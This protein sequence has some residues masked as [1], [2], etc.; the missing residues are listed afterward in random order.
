MKILLSFC[1][2]IGAFALLSVLKAFGADYTI[3]DLGAGSASDIND[4]GSVVGVDTS[5]V[6]WYYHKGIKQGLTNIVVE[7]MLNPFGEHE[8]RYATS[9]SGLRINNQEYVAGLAAS[10]T[11]SGNGWVFEDYAPPRGG[12]ITVGGV[13]TG[14]YQVA[15]NDSTPLVYSYL[16]Y[17]NPFDAYS[18]VSLVMVPSVGQYVNLGR[19]YQVVN[20]VNNAG[21]MAGTVGEGASGGAFTDEVFPHPA[22]A[23]IISNLIVNY[24]DPRS[25]GSGFVWEF[26]P[27]NRLS[28]AYGINS[29]GHVVGDMSLVLFSTNKNAFIY[30][31][32]GLENLGTLGGSYST[33]SDINNSDALVG[34]S[35]ATDG[36]LRAFLWTDGIMQDLNALISVDSGW[37]LTKAVAINNFGQIVGEGMHEGAVHAFL[38]SPPGLATAPY[39]TEEPVGALLGVD[40]AYQLSVTAIGT[41]P[42]NYQWLKDGTN[43]PSQ[44]NSVF[45][46]PGVSGADAGTYQAVV[47]NTRGSANSKVVRIDVL[48]PKLAI[49]SQTE[50]SYKLTINGHIGGNY[51]ME[52]AAHP[53][54]AGGWTPVSDF[55]LTNSVQ[56]FV[57]QALG[58][59]TERYYRCVRLP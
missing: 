18:A 44:T 51:R 58:E 32:S 50:T 48:D 5:S 15:L 22:R 30:R 46:F 47:S 7:D 41:S 35:T 9:V 6:G 33:A 13:P 21:L 16:Q 2:S 25:P 1:L 4:A 8:Y 43:L 12:L 14:T 19:D 17:H 55:Q 37:V 36:S 3:T 52:Y 27:T 31:G 54:G 20:A 53:N 24:I 34:Q 23:C 28:D 49:D 38:L 26:N 45:D 59:S 39:V 29:Q 10:A 57:V 11:L 42:L 40:A 56:V